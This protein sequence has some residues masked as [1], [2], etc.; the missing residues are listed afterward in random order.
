MS[1]NKRRQQFIPNW[2]NNRAPT[3]TVWK[4][5][6]RAAAESTSTNTNSIHEESLDLVPMNDLQQGELYI[7]KI[8]LIAIALFQGE[9]R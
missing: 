4:H 5:H 7:I 8:K 3:A 9:E 2:P 6:T 1:N